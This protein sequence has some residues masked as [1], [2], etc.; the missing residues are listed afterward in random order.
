M[1]VKVKNIYIYYYY[2]F[3]KIELVIRNLYIGIIIIYYYLI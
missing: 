3:N 2:Y 1:I